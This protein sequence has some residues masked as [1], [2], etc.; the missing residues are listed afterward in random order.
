MAFFNGTSSF[1]PRIQDPNLWAEQGI[2]I[3]NEA[4]PTTLP[5]EMGHY[6]DLFH[7]PGIYFGYEN[8][9]RT[10]GCA[11]WSYTGDLLEGTPADPSYRV[12]NA[13]INHI[14]CQWINPPIKPL[15]PDGCGKTTII[16]LLII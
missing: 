3:K 1:S 14:N 11:N 16:H 4:P 6:F 7:T 2:I 10:G 9:A 12:Q 5:H 15:P 8:I 13:T